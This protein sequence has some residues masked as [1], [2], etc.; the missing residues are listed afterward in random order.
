MNKLYNIYKKNRYLYISLVNSHNQKGGFEQI[1]KTD[2]KFPTSEGWEMIPNLGQRNCG[3]F[4][5]NNDITRILKCQPKTATA[6]AK[7]ISVDKLA[8]SLTYPVFPNIYNVYTHG[9]DMYIEMQRFSGDLTDLLF[10]KLPRKILDKMVLDEEIT[11][12]QSDQIM[13]LYEHMINRT[14]K[15]KHYNIGIYT[16]LDDKMFTLMDDSEFQKFI[17]SPDFDI[18]KV[19]IGFSNNDSKMYVGQV[20]TDLKKIR[21][22]F[23]KYTVTKDMY[24]NFSKKFKNALEMMIPEVIIQMSMIEIVLLKNNYYYRDMKY[25]NFAYV[26]EDERR[27]HLGIDWNNNKFDNRY[28]YVYLLDW[29]SG[30]EISTED[31]Y[32]VIYSKEIQ[33]L[34][35]LKNIKRI[36]IHGQYSINNI[37]GP[38]IR[39]PVELLSKIAPQEVIEIITHQDPWFELNF[40]E[41]NFNDLDTIQKHLTSDG[42]E[43][44]KLNLQS[45][46][47]NMYTLKPIDG[48][49]NRYKTIKSGSGKNNFVLID[50]EDNHTY[51]IT[52]GDNYGRPNVN[53][54]TWPIGKFTT[55]DVKVAKDLIQSPYNS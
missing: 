53:D 18:K 38:L 21:D 31:F 1:E 19:D 48:V 12:D 17:E 45:E 55:H 37:Q 6:Y 54:K 9:S 40:I 7:I 24:D 26:L 42:I 52:Y 43:K 47:G 22:R 4:I 44:A 16:K 13:D 15:H 8:S 29:D 11:A 50:I 36:S 33:D 49:E 5:K 39:Y 41:R 32:K 34:Y 27:K 25:D 51:I 14:M 20:I 10:H 23:G 2:P 30:L 35:N 28:F 3:I 46:L